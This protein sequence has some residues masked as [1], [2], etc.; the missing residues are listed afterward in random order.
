MDNHSKSN[1][2]KS[3]NGES[4]C[5]FMGGIKKHSAGGGTNNSSWWPN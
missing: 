5:P 2:N 3:S 1:P 4:K